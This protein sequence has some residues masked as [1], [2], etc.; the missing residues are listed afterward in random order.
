MALA[1]VYQLIVKQTIHGQDVENVFFYE[2]ISTGGSAE[3]LITAFVADMSSGMRALQVFALK[4]VII[5]AQ[6]L[7]NLSDFHEEPQTSAGAFG[8]AD[9]LPSFNAVSYTLHPNTRAVRPGGKRIAGIPEAASL[10]GEIVEP[11]YLAAME[12]F[13]LL[14]DD[15]LDGTLDDYQPVIVKRIKTAVPDT[16]PP[17]FTYSLPSGSDVPVLGLVK[18]ATVSHNV[19]SQVSRK[20]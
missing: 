2:A 1:D 18:S 12:A 15:N 13:R 17:K 7:G 9:V 14:L 8:D 20:D 11:G 16:V 5:K 10:N 6:S 4:W 19:S 3:D